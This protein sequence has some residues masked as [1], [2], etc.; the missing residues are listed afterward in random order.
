MN[1]TTMII[2]DY[3]MN[4]DLETELEAEK[5]KKAE[6]EVKK[7]LKDTKIIYNYEHIGFLG[8]D[9]Y[10][11]IG[12]AVRCRCRDFVQ[13]ETRR[14]I[15]TTEIEAGEAEAY[16]TFLEAKR[17]GVTDRKQLTKACAAAFMRA[18]RIGADSIPDELRSYATAELVADPT[19]TTERSYYRSD[20][21]RQAPVIISYNGDESDYF[22]SVADPIKTIEQYMVEEDDRDEH[23]IKMHQLNKIL[24]SQG[25]D[26][27]NNGDLAEIERV[28]PY[29]FFDELPPVLVQLQTAAKMSQIS[30]KTLSD[31]RIDIIVPSSG[32]SSSYVSLADAMAQRV[33]KQHMGFR[34]SESDPADQQV[35]DKKIEVLNQ[36]INHPGSPFRYA[37]RGAEIIGKLDK[38]IEA[39][40][41]SIDP[42]KSDN[43]QLF[44]PE[45]TI[46]VEQKGQRSVYDAADWA[47]EQHQSHVGELG[48]LFNA[49]DW[50]TERL[51]HHADPAAAELLA[52]HRKMLEELAAINND[53]IDVVAAAEK[54][55]L[56]EME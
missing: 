40:Y 47:A 46:P 3:E 32:A 30:A 56:A 48:Y 22:D 35:I 7:A 10:K 14:D 36:I 44:V 51:R 31:G 25:F 27:T 53:I 49:A 19:K 1:A 42:K 55:E 45:Q 13:R 12:I 37:S 52:K 15:R 39:E 23:Y 18:I 28:V 8:D 9:E 24:L 29:V 6:K 33:K 41:Q 20:I 26:T 54:A 5:A 4:S 17:A 2:D 11:E 34:G 16:Y 38:W 21:E 50:G 43:Y